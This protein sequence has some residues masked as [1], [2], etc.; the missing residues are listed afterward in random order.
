MLAPPPDRIMAAPATGSNPHQD[1][2]LPPLLF[3][4]GLLS[5]LLRSQTLATTLVPIVPPF[6][7][8]CFPNQAVKICEILPFHL[9]SLSSVASSLPSPNLLFFSVLAEV[10][11]GD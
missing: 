2:C 9:S 7:S 4:Y 11:G 3:V 5:S 1:K 6:T 10:A 8:L